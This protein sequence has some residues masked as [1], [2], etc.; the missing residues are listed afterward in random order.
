MTR[1]MILENLYEGVIILDKDDRIIEYNRKLSEMVE[2]YTCLRKYSKFGM[3]FAEMK[4][5]L[6]DYEEIVREYRKFRDSHLSETQSDIVANIGSERIHLILSLQKTYSSHGE[7]T[8]MIIKLIDMTEYH[9]LLEKLEDKNRELHTINVQLNENI[10]VRK[11]LV[12][13]QER[14]RASKE[15]HDILGHSVT[16]VITLLEN[17]R[18][19]FESKPEFAKEKVR[20]AMEVTRNGLNELK[21]SLTKKKES[22]I[23]T[24]MIIEDLNALID[25]FTFQVWRLN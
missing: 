12:I 7:F 16:L 6:S 20:Q 22:T 24:E 17:V 9:T 14:N 15:V 11:R 19:S 25:E 18:S 8:G 23:V 2:P 4:D 3:L 21:L 5:F 13:E 1:Q 10:S